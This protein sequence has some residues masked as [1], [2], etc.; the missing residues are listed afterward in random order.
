MCVYDAVDGESESTDMHPSQAAA[1]KQ[2]GDRKKGK[3]PSW[4]PPAEVC[5]SF[6]TDGS[7]MR[8]TRARRTEYNLYTKNCH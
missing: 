2:Q 7:S 4:Y 8:Q 3:I 1:I 6:S 5:H